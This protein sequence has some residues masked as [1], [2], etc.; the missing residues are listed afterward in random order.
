MAHSE[1]FNRIHTIC[2]VAANK[3]C[4]LREHQVRK[5]REST[6]HERQYAQVVCHCLVV[7]AA[8]LVGGLVVL[9]R[10]H[11]G[12]VEEVEL[13]RE[14]VRAAQAQERQEVLR[15]GPLSHCPGMRRL[16][17]LPRR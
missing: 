16:L 2:K 13:R 8:D 7:I 9:R 5:R 3:T 4:T 11:G 12:L 17:L 14:Q 15:L 1:A 6:L 10:H